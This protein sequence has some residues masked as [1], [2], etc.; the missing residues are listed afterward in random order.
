[1]ILDK[2]AHWYDMWNAIV[3]AINFLNEKK[4]NCTL[5]LIISNH[6]GIICL[7]NLL[8]L[9]SCNV[10][11][12]VISGILAHW[13]DMWNTIV[14]AID[15]CN[16]KKL[17]WEL[18]FILSNH[19]GI[20]CLSNPL[21]LE[22]CNVMFKIISDIMSHWYDMWNTIVIA[23]NFTNE[24]KMICTLMFIKSNHYGNKCLSNLL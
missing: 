22:P 21:Q 13:Y 1:M 24:K 17:I 7:S 14:I 3:I 20:K 16:A 11:L 6:Y 8:L 9:E 5:V 4:M 19:D 18:I 2:M 12:N 23:I 15:F 10:M